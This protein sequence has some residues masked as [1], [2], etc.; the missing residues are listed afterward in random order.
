MRATLHSRPHWLGALPVLIGLGACSLPS[1]AP[2]DPGGARVL[3]STVA[4][5]T[6]GAELAAAAAQHAGVPVRDLA[7]L[8]GRTFVLT[9]DCA[10]EASCRQ[11]MARLGADPGF[12][13]DV[14]PDQRRTLPT[15]PSAS[16]A[17]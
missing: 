5:W 12:A 13:R 11:A 14:Q 7:A 3:L 16:S 2:A 10:D 6:A 4:D 8:G 9:L 1:A 17:L 15:R